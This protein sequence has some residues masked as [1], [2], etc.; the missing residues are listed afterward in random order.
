MNDS[1]KPWLLLLTAVSGLVDSA[2]YLKL[3]HVFVANMTG[4]IVFVGFALAGASGL[5]PISTT[6]AVMAFFGG[7]VAAG[8]LAR[9][10]AVAGPQLLR[11]GT[12]LQL[13][14][15]LSVVLVWVLGSPTSNDLPR[16]L[17]VILLAAAMGVQSVMTSR[18][19]IPGFN[20]TVVLTTM[21]STL[22][23]ESRLAGGAGGHNRWRMMAI[24]S[25]LSGGLIGAI[26]LYHVHPIAPLLL[27]AVLVGGVSLN[28]HWLVVSG[29]HRQ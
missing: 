8:R 1:L 21:L 20:S 23:A 9:R 7:S 3:G 14:I 15:L 5:S 28:A 26:L 27:A 6:V 19:A 17:V 24:L 13:A 11:A 2:S 29:S 16:Y 22:A 10:V 25:M 4:N 18:L 12:A